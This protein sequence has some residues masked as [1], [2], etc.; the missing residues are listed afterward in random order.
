[1]GAGVP[2]LCEPASVRMPAAGLLGCLPRVQVPTTRK[3]PA[4]LACSAAT[5]PG[6]QGPTTAPAARAPRGTFFRPLQTEILLYTPFL[7]FSAYTPQPWFPLA[8]CPYFL[9]L[10]CFVLFC[11][12]SVLSPWL[13]TLFFNEQGLHLLPRSSSADPQTLFVGIIVRHTTKLSSPKA[14][15]KFLQ[16][17]TKRSQ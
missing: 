5:R 16:N 3:G 13:C 15:E 2:V 7:K 8:S 12:R 9:G 17:S 4:G 1:M 10:F 11:C 6:S 14:L